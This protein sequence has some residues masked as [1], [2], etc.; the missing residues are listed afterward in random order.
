MPLHRQN[1]CPRS[2]AKNDL[3]AFSPA[4]DR[5]LQEALVLRMKPDRAFTA[6]TQV[7]LRPGVVSLTPTFGSVAFCSFGVVFVLR[8]SFNCNANVVSDFAHHASC[9]C[10]LYCVP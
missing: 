7:M 1:E 2:V 8:V 6:H 10:V 4:Y 9:E 3:L 5:G